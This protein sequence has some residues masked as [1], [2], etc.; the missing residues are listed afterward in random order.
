MDRAREGSVSAGAAT[1]KAS[2]DTS[3][4]PPPLLSPLW[5]VCSRSW[6]QNGMGSWQA[7][8]HSRGGT[9]VQADIAGWRKLCSLGGLPGGGGV[10]IGLA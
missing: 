3:V 7:T 2:Q 4:S 9:P 6:M 1:K 8:K 5:G 10:G